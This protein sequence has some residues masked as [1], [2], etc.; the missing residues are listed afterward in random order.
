[1]MSA[2]HSDRTEEVD[3]TTVAVEQENVNN[4]ERSTRLETTQNSRLIERAKS[5]AEYSWEFLRVSNSKLSISFE[6][7]LLR[8]LVSLHII[9]TDNREF[10]S[11]CR[12][13]VTEHTPWRDKMK[14]STLAILIDTQTC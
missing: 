13:L 4:N 8:R 10:H 5:V 1:M 6:F 11:H 14:Q 7:Q 9:Q 2:A 12:H 3:D